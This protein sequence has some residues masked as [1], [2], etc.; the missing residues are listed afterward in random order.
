MHLIDWWLE[1]VDP[2][3]KES[4]KRHRSWLQGQTLAYLRGQV[5]GRSQK[6]IGN[7]A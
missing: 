2:A 5:R 6:K 3:T 7:H 4:Q 1:R